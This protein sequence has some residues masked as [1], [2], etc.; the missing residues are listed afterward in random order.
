M[1]K[2]IYG[3]IQLKLEIILL[4][5]NSLFPALIFNVSSKELASSE[6]SH[7][8]DFG[9]NILRLS[10]L[11]CLQATVTKHS[12]A[13]IPLNSLEKKKPNKLYFPPVFY[14]GMI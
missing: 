6:M 9:R 11:W 4:H 13:D 14:C 5:S 7:Q 8:D 2:E 3:T 1:L 10:L 12:A